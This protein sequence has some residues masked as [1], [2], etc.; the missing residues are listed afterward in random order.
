MQRTVAG[1]PTPPPAPGPPTP[2]APAAAPA[3]AAP[4]DRRAPAEGGR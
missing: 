3:A 4:T 2:G 1:R